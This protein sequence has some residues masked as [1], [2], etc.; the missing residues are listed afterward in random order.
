MNNANE[1]YPSAWHA[2]ID[3]REQAVHLVAEWI[4]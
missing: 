4:S 3:T 2:M 1:G